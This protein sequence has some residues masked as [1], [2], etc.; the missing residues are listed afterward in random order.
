MKTL[1]AFVLALVVGVWLGL[2]VSQGPSGA[3]VPVS[4]A[5]AEAAR[6]YL[7]AHLAPMPEGWTWAT[8]EPEPGVALEVG[9]A[10]AAGEAKGTIAFVPGYSAPV[11]MYGA[12][13]SRLQAAGWNVAAITPRGQGRSPRF[14][15]DPEMGWVDDFATHAADLAAFLATLDGPVGVLANSMGG[16]VALRAALDHQPGVLGYALVAPMVEVETAPFPAPVA[17]GIGRTFTALGLGD[18]YAP[19]RGQWNDAAMFDDAAVLA[20]GT[21]C[22]RDAGRA[23][24]REALFAL[25]PALRVGGPSARWVAAT[26]RGQAVLETRADEIG[27]PILMATAGADRVVRTEAASALCT[28][29]PACE[30]V[31]Y[32][33]ARHCMFEDT[34]ATRTRL[35]DDA[36]AFFGS[37]AGR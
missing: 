15:P 9:R 10:P 1:L 8:F 31:R 22:A 34:E 13:L 25:E 27:A 6:A 29:M 18:T 20:E 32:A 12:E 36:L 16:H 4:D 21:D 35:V 26:Y 33:E 5:Q 7:D 23:H 37:L 14:G 19:G 11:D 3:P 2:R 28:A 24:L 17:R 30:E